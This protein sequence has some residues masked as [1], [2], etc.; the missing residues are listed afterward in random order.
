MAIAAAQAICLLGKE[1][2]SLSRLGTSGVIFAPRFEYGRGRSAQRRIALTKIRASAGAKNTEIKSF[3]GN[4]VDL[5]AYS[6]NAAYA[7]ANIHV[8]RVLKSFNPAI[9]DGEYL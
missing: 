8:S 9:R 2:P 3:K 4:F 6:H 5:I 7:T 1:S